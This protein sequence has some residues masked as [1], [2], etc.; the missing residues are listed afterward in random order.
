MQRRVTIHDIAKRANVAPSTVSRALRNSKQVSESKREELKALADE[1]GY[2]P[3]P[4]ISAYASQRRSGRPSAIT[5]IA[6]ITSVPS[7]FDW[8]QIPFFRR[9]HVGMHRRAEQLGYA[10]ENFGLREAGMSA[11]RLNDVLY[12]R[13]IQALCFG[14][15]MA[16][17]PDCHFDWERFSA[18]SLC[19]SLTVPKLHRAIAHHFHSIIL[20]LG[21]LRAKGYKRI[22][23]CMKKESVEWTEGLWHA[24]LLYFLQQYP[25]IEVEFISLGDELSLVVDWCR[26][27]RIEVVLEIMPEVREVLHASGL[28]AEGLDY[29]TLD[30]NPED[31]HIAGVD[32][33]AERIGEL[34]VD[35]VISMLKAGETGIPS[36]AT[37]VMSEV[38]WV[39]GP[40]LR[41]GR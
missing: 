40:S 1:M 39:D 5:T 12:H 17:E 34:A 9:C 2:R 25:E 13:G 41:R 30:W 18:I 37:A 38:S 15:E 27:K 21:E 7:G 14:P 35:L 8:G 10:V 11:R 6:F 33:N 26:A 16:R 32:Q 4:L 31:A 20:A 19:H 29:A 22:G 24:G 36:A 23:F 3:S 28:V